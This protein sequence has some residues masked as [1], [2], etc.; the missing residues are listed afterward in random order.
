MKTC[1]DCTRDLPVSAFYAKSSISRISSYCR[2][3]CKARSRAYIDANR[4]VVLAKNKARY[5]K[6]KSAVLAQQRVYYQANKQR[7][8]DAQRKTPEENRAHIKAWRE[9]NPDKHKAAKRRQT[10]LLNDGYVRERLVAKTK[11]RSLDIPQGLV[12]LKRAQLKLLR[13]LNKDQS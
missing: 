10:A 13:Q 5:K 3:C 1:C 2:E 4:A 7:I 9:K 12:D 11:L 8:L 6:N